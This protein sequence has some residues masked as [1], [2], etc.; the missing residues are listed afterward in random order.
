M[1]VEVILEKNIN[2]INII[3]DCFLVIGMS[4]VFCLVS[5]EFIFKKLLGVYVVFVNFVNV[6]VVVEFDNIV[7][8]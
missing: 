6:I 2:I 8:S 4:C 7:I 5:V 3:K 1:S